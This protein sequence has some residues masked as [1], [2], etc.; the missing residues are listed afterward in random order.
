MEVHYP[1]LECNTKARVG[2]TESHESM[3]P[4]ELGISTAALRCSPLISG[5]GIQRIVV[6]P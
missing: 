5:D 1:N 4:V 3:C 2:A 6:A